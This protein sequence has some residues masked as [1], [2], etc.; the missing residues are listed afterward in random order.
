V[1]YNAKT[2]KFVLWFHLD[3]SNY[4]LAKLGVAVSDNVEGPYSFVKGISP[5]DTDS[6]DMTVWVDDDGTGYVIYATAVN[7]NTVIARLT[8]D[9]LDVESKVYQFDGVRWEA[10]AMFKKNG[11]YY[12]I[13]SGTTGWN[14]NSNYYTYSRY[15]NQSWAPAEK[16]APYSSNTYNSQSNNV[17]VLDD[18]TFIFTADRWFSSA[19]ADSR[20]IWL[21]IEFLEN[22]AIRATWRSE[23]WVDTATGRYGNSNSR[24]FEGED[25]TLVALDGGAIVLPCSACSNGLSAGYVGKN[26]TLEISSV[27]AAR[28]STYTVIVGFQNGDS[29]SRQ[30]VVSVNGIQ[31]LTLSFPSTGTSVKEFVFH[32]QLTQGANSIRLSNPNGY[33]PDFDYFRVQCSYENCEL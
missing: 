27:N 14:S 31:Q 5:F 12:L 4:G 25:G 19:L 9:Y 33:A 11:L 8:P 18:G 23:W 29:G 16:I 20:Y 24:K 32:V 2:N 22:N 1:I 26:G 7:L 21:P 17:I 6:R 28:N 10:Y 30:A 15:L 13:T 3:S